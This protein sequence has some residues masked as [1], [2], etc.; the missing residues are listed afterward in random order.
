M[1]DQ[2]T[3]RYS[4]DADNRLLKVETS[5]DG[6]IWDRDAAYSYYLHGPLMRSAIGEDSVQGVDYVYTLQ[7]WLKGMNHP[8]LATS[9]DPGK[10][11]ASGS[12]YARDAYGM[13][14]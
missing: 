12:R 11:G 10:D 13:M 3:H 7:G 14:L 5:R 2:F 9:K 6:K 4:Y 1:H 8:S